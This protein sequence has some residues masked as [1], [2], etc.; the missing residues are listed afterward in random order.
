MTRFA[1]AVTGFVLASCV[2][3][4][5][6]ASD[7]FP[8]KPVHIVVNSAPGGLTDIAA[9][10][11]A[12]KMTESLK[13]P[14]LV[15]NR[16]GADT[17]LG[18]R[19]VKGAPADG[20]TLLATSDTIASQPVVKLDAGYDLQDFVGIGVI[21]RSPW[22]VMIGTSQ[23][24]NNIPEFIARA[25]AQP[26]KLTFASGGVGTTPHLAAQMFLQ[27]AGVKLL[28]VPYKGLAAGMP[29]VM[30]GRVTMIFEAVGASAGKVRAGQIRALGVTSTTR[31]GVL[32]DIPTVQE[33]G[34]PGYS[35]YV[36]I[37]LLAPAGTPRAIVDR[38][39]A[40]LK[41]ATAS[42]EIRERLER[43]G[44]EQLVMS[45]EE[46]TESLNNARAEFSKLVADLG[47]EKQ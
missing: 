12:Q 43:D 32:P 37:G 29:D 45:P 1:G 14:V 13:Q 23:P 10:L 6:H 19:Y 44:A 31:L 25:K 5:A 42:K 15:E 38:L 46:Y 22:L 9:R 16:A 33:Q 3:A 27:R 35:S 28:H 8:S 26:D 21:A 24:D 20:Y 34:V 7:A 4:L 11:V 40:A 47:L 17:M 39:A 36:N 30:G 2:A 18:T 41:G